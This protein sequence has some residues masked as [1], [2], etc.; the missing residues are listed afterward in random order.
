MFVMNA[1]GSAREATARAVVDTGWLGSRLTRTDRS[2]TS[3]FPY[4]ICVLAVNT[5]FPCGSDVARDPTQDLFNPA[6]SPDGTLAA[7]VR[8]PD[9]DD[10]RGGDRHLRRRD[11]RAGARARRRRE[12]PADVVARR[13]ADRVRARRRPLRGAGHRR[14][15]RT[16]DPPR[17]GAADLDE[18][19]R[20]HAAGPGAAPRSPGDRHRLRP[21]AGPAHDHAAQGRPA[22]RPARG[23]RRHRRLGHRAAAPARGSA[24]GELRAG[25]LLSST[26]PSGSASRPAARTP[27]SARRTR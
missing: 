18:R 16:P 13:E 21:A 10:R 12:H 3:P 25:A 2:G 14:P 23:R 1:D 26:R 17:R 4:G 22:G 15:A 9:T 6:F 11:R 19:A 7:A 5:D 24:A 27:R 8:S 20:V